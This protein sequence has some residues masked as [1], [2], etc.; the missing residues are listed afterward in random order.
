[1]SGELLTVKEVA[2][3]LRVSDETVYR[4]C[5]NKRIRASRVEWQ[6]RIPREAVDEFLQSGVPLEKPSGK[7]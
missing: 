3:L 7:E 5:R 4:L 6:W 1:M 2:D